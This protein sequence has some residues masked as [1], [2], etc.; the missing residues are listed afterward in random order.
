MLPVAFQRYLAN[1]GGGLALSER[2]CFLLLAIF[3][4]WNTCGKHSQLTANE[5]EHLSTAKIARL[6]ALDRTRRLIFNSDSEEFDYPD[7]DTAEGLMAVRMAP[8]IPTQVDTICWSVLGVCG[9]APV[10]DS[11]RQP[12]WGKPAHGAVPPGY[13]LYAGNIER[14]IEAGLCPLQ[15]VTDFAH[16]HDKELLASIR[17][18]D[19]HDSF[20]AGMQT[21]WKQQHNELLVKA[22]G[23][24]PI[25]DL[26][27][28]SQDFNHVA[29][30]D[31]KF[32]IIEEVCERYDVDGVELDYIRHPVLFSS[33]YQGDLATAEEVAVMTNL[34]RRIRQRLEKIAEQ[35]G[36]PLLIAARI[37]DNF[38][39][40]RN[41]GLNVRA[42]LR[43]DLVD[44]LFLGGGY[45]PAWLDVE[46]IAVEAHRNGVRV[47]P[48]NNWATRGFD[49]GLGGFLENS[50]ALSARWL[51]QGADGT[52]YWNVGTPLLKLSGESLAQRRSDRYAPLSE[53]GTLRSLAGKNKVYLLEKAH[54]LDAYEFISSS[55]PL[56]ATV[57]DHRVVTIAL[58]VG[59]DAQAV[60]A[61]GRSVDLRLGVD[62]VEPVDPLRLVVK[63]NGETLE[64][65]PDGGPERC[66]TYRVAIPMLNAGNNKLQVSGAETG[67]VTEIQRVHLRIRYE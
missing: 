9:D 47:Y 32:E 1:H 50:R 49:A 13:A 28:T 37:P 51:R 46:E 38:K 20:I 11:Q 16:A 52:Y 35:R 4:H 19:V 67:I 65:L 29:V 62:L 53:T 6:R 59:D 12:V 26:Y 40:S 25:S 44:M 30:R 57:A 15:I 31:R 22:N 21:Q 33:V 14:L 45:A 64:C 17:M 54:F 27:R 5:E 48:C 56:P 24:E 2:T 63:L 18:N 34:M 58:K 10:Y 23:R 3:L 66:I 60:F 43:E 42:W 61:E 8:L 7:A 55:S 36:R 39:L 41:I